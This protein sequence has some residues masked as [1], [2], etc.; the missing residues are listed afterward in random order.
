MARILIIDECNECP[1]CDNGWCVARG[2]PER[3]PTGE[4]PDFCPLAEATGTQE[5]DY[6]LKYLV[7]KED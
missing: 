1:E 2:G 7:A 3:I 6:R 5:Y 4:I